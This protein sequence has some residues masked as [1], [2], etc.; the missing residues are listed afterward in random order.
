MNQNVIVDQYIK[1]SKIDENYK[2][3]Q[4]QLYNAIQSIISGSSGD[5]LNSNLI[6]NKMLIKQMNEPINE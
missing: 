1:S 6:N 3:Q 4:N 5:Q 2:K